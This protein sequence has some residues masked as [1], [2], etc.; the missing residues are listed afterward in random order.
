MTNIDINNMTSPFLIQ[1]VKDKTIS[2][3]YNGNKQGS[4]CQCVVSLNKAL[5]TTPELKCPGIMCMVSTKKPTLN[6][7]VFFGKKAV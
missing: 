1:A 7:K 2:P 5:V 4:Q 3:H 6:H